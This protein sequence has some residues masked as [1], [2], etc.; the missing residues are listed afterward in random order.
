MLSGFR[1]KQT[2]LIRNLPALLTNETYLLFPN[3]L[4]SSET[5]NLAG[6]LHS[7]IGSSSGLDL[8]HFFLEVDL[9]KEIFAFV[10][11]MR[12]TTFQ[13]NSKQGDITALAALR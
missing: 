8:S 12:P 13:T 5:S 3:G 10:I 1:E 7:K 4:R 11:L 9:S 6:T 2:E